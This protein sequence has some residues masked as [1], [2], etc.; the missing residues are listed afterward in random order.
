MSDSTIANPI[1]APLQTST[2]YVQVTNAG[3]CAGVDS[4]IVN[5]FKGSVENGYKLP[6]AF[7]P[8]NDGNND[9]FNVRKWGTLASLDFSVYDRW[10]SL[11]FHTKNPAECWDGTYKGIKQPTGTYV[12]QIRAQ[13]LCGTVY[14]KG[15]V[16]LVR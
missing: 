1:A 5:V 8:N 14:R 2:Y 3:G 10:G 13:A 15:T 16:V 9:C 12:Y 4:I 11:I 6:S 7:T